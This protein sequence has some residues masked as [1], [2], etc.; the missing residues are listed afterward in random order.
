MHHG[1]QPSKL[2][3]DGEEDLLTTAD[4]AFPEPVYH[5][6]WVSPLHRSL[7]DDPYVCSD[8]LP[9]GATLLPA[10]LYLHQQSWALEFH[11]QARASAECGA[12]ANWH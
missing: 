8:G 12:H 6:F 3:A 1:M 4:Q 11:I 9:A 2:M 10:S 7:Q 5:W